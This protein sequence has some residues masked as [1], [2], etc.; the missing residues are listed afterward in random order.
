MSR[1]LRSSAS[2]LKL[3]ILAGNGTGRGKQACLGPIR[4]AVG[5][6]VLRPN[7]PRPVIPSQG[8][9]GRV[10]LALVIVCA[11][12]IIAGCGGDDEAE[13]GRGPAQKCEDFLDA[14]CNKNAECALPTERA[15]L[16]EDCRF[17]VTLDIDCGEV[18]AVSASYS[19]CID[20]ILAA[21]CG[22]DGV[23][24]PSSCQRVLLR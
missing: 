24:L 2:N 14:W 22:S 4:R 20:A 6:D 1:R 23:P 17:V 10:L 15:R 21:S 11:A 9:M 19:A 13:D 7:S 5:A 16:R 18:R 8:V 3:R 12:P